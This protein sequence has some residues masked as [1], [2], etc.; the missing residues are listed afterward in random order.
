MVGEEY[1]R[2]LERLGTD[3]LRQVAVLRMEGL[4]GDEIAAKLGCARRTVVR[5]LSLIRRTLAEK[6]S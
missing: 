1:R 5:Q 2:L 6:S 3:S 4:T